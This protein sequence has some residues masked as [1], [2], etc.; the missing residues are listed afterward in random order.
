M[1]SKWNKQPC[2]L[3]AVGTLA[4]GIRQCAQPYKGHTF[5]SKEKGAFCNHCGDGFVEF[6]QANEAA[7]LVFRSTVDAACATELANIRKKLKLT[8]QQAAQIAGGGKNA[9]SRYERGVTK[10]VAAVVNLFRLLDRHP[11]LLREVR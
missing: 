3:C 8:Q 4:D 6:E 1:A 5:H 2:P 9:F 11:E 10:P 7:W